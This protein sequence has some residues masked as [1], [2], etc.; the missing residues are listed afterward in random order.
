[1]IKI[2]LV[3]LQTILL[4]IDMMASNNQSKKNDVD[5][6]LEKIEKNF[7]SKNNIGICNESKKTIEIINKNIL[8]LRQIE[9]NYDWRGIKALLIDNQTKYCK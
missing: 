9:P 4:P 8:S 5:M 6:Y 1:M 7:K 3:L 2:S